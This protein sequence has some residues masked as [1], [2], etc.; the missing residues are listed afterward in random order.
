MHICISINIKTNFMKP[1]TTFFIVTLLLMVNV[2]KAQ[3]KQ[4]ITATVVNVS[5]NTGKVG[6]ALYDKTSFMKR[7][8]KAKKSEIINGK[9]TV[10]FK[11]LE[12]GTYAILCYHDKN[13][14]NK[15]DFE[16]SGIPLEDY[17]A[18]NNASSPYG[19]PSFN[20]AKF[21]LTDKN[22]SLDI[23]F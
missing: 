21:I 4:T 11:N 18:S 5:S 15:M 23:R 20:D 10:I 19:P 6:F 22:V 17:G 16:P 2:L 7:P 13:G 14:N 9:S 1:V 3:E 8:I 12:K